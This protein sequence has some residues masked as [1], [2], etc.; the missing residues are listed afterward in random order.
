MFVPKSSI[1]RFI[2]TTV[3]GFIAVIALHLLI[4]SAVLA[5]PGGKIASTIFR[6]F[7]GKVL[8]TI[9]T[10]IFLPL[11][12]YCYIVELLAEH[13]TLR[14]LKLLSQVSNQF[15][16]IQLKERV[17]ECFHRI[18]SAWRHED[19]QQ[20]SEWMTNW[21]WRNQQI[22]YLDQWEQDGLVNHCRVRSINSICPLFIKVYKRAGS[23]NGSR[24]AVKIS[25][26]MEDY[27]AE[28]QTGKVVQGQKG[29]ADVTSVWTFKLINGQW[30]VANIEESSM[31]TTYA[32]TV[33][34]IPILF[35]GQSA[36]RG[37]FGKSE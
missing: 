31:A 4:P 25:A 5:A 28:R 19:M 21:Y 20:A 1:Y 22:A 35:S 26:N 17:I 18:H 6:T 37:Q 8:L 15:D 27:L 2:F 33:N 30:V 10:I 14:D 32:K 9:L 29:Y 24:L 11:I 23:Y 16:W 36:N 3:L 13:R 12:I 7:W 34:E